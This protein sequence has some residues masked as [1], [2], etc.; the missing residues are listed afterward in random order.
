M[1]SPPPTAGH[2][3][4]Q[5]AVLALLAAVML[6]ATGCGDSDESAE[7]AASESPSP[8]QVSAPL[9]LSAKLVRSR[10]DD[11]NR[12]L[13]IELTNLGEQPV[14]VDELR[15]VAP[16]YAPEPGEISGGRQLRPGQTTAY[17]I[18]HGDPECAGDEPVPGQ[19]QVELTSGE[20]HVTIDPGESADLIGRMLTVD[21]ARQRILD[22]V[23]IRFDTEWELHSNGNEQVGT[24]LIERRNG[25]PAV[26]LTGVRHNINYTLEMLEPNSKPTLE[27]GEKTLAVPVRTRGA[28]CGGHAMGDNSKPFEFSAYLSVVGGPEALVEFTAEDQE[29]NFLRLCSGR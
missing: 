22:I 4:A 21:C 9:E 16:P 2:Q 19:V 24:L 11:A 20:Q 15:L 7:P 25:G 8:D 26:T 18:T 23:D 1:P 6:L 28:N 5:R 27:E 10:R 13:R 3:R 29:E 14:P 12:R 17:R